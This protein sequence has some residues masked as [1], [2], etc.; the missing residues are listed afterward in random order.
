MDRLGAR[1]FRDEG[2]DYEFRETLRSS[3]GKVHDTGDKKGAMQ[4]LEAGCKADI[5]C[6]C[7]WTV[8]VAAAKGHGRLY[9]DAY[10]VGSSDDGGQGASRR[11]AKA[12]LGDLKHKLSQVLAAE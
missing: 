4:S 11:C 12:P 8:N 1:V 3:V 5:S 2:L 7:H 6:A 10:S 9:G